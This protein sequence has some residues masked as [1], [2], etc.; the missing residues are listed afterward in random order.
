M[1]KISLVLT[2]HNRTQML[3][4]A[5]SA[6]LFDERISDIIIA[7]DNSNEETRYWLLN[8]I[9]GIDKVKLY[10]HDINVGM[11]R[12]KARAVGYASNE[13][14]IVFDSDNVLT[15]A[16]ID[17]I[18]GGIPWDSKVIYCP[19][20]AQPQFD[21]RQWNALTFDKR[22]VKRY[23]NVKMFD[24]LLNTCNYF[25][26]KDEYLKVYK[27]NP[28]MKGTDTIWFNYLWL[29][30]GNS[31]HVVP[32]MH[33]DHRVH[34]GSGFMADVHYNMKKAG[35]VKKMISKL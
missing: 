2:N 25:V 31:F 14:C 4:E 8:R 5:F 17:A 19:S 15:K 10:Y 30:A 29:K 7:D 11:S 33:Y 3:Y 22:S 18:Y 9:E 28:Q 34:E 6:A 16:Y 12:N 1:E 23:L 35:E 24:C 13:W 32:G 21:Y 27:H 26:H 20:F